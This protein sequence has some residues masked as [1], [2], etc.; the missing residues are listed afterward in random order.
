MNSLHQRGSDHFE[1]VFVA[2][3]GIEAV[4]AESRRTFDR[5]SH[6]TFGIGVIERG[7]QRSLSGRGPVQAGPRDVITCNP[8]E[9]HDGAPIGD[10]GRFW[11]ML[12][13]E[14]AVVASTVP[15]LNLRRPESYEFTRP[16]LSDPSVATLVRRLFAAMTVVRPVM[17]RQEELLLAL[18]RQVGDA[19][20]TLPKAGTPGAIARARARIDDDPTAAVTLADL[21]QE[22]GLSRWQVLRGFAKST[23]F[24]PHAYLMQKRMDLAR[25]LIAGGMQLAEVSAASGFA[26]QSHMT[27]VFRRRYGFTPKAWAAGLP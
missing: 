23:G 5:H 6:D 27:R 7:A 24:T 16:A 4:V 12:Y 8:G 17:L 25:R 13:F 10:G 2:A 20:E 26:D 22:T 19:P 14:P 9:V 18:L 11:R 3:P 1:R 21:A 15:D